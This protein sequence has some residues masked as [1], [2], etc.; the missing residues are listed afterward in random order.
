MKIDHYRGDPDFKYIICPGR[1]SGTLY[2]SEIGK[3]LFQR[4]R[5]TIP[6][7][8]DFY[9]IHILRR[10][11]G[12]FCG[13]PFTAGEGFV[14]FPDERCWYERGEEWEVYWIKF[15]GTEAAKYLR[16]IGVSESGVLDFEQSAAIFDRL[17]E[18]INSPERA[19]F[20]TEIDFLGILFDIFSSV[21]V[22][23]GAIE[24]PSDYV[25]HAK[26]Y[27]EENYDMDISVSSIAANLH[28]SEKHFWR[29][30]KEETG[31][32]PKQYIIECRLRRAEGLLRDVPGIKV[33]EI[34]AS[35]GYGSPE[36]F[37][38][39]YKRHRGRS[40]RDGK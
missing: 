18:F 27:I 17:D 8:R 26:C 1:L 19:E 30:F 10:G 2:V 14:S 7:Y 16:G 24:R 15:G 9:T 39:V 25:N 23:E 36:A 37:L 12:R 4:E 22:P 29:V 13:V 11:D 35:V 5:G 21:R 20:A 32:S 34:A 38:Q 28:I 3:R 33:S 6:S 31:I 40:F